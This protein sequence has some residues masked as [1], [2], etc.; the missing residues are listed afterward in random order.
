[1]SSLPKKVTVLV[2]SREQKPLVFPKSIAWVG[3][4]RETQ[5]SLSLRVVRLDYGDYALEGYEDC[6]VVERKGSLSEL[7]SN[8]F[9]T[10]LGRQAKS[11]R[12][13]VDYCMY[14]YLLLEGNPAALYRT[15]KDYR[16]VP[17]ELREPG[18]V[19]D[20]LL[21]TLGAYGIQLLWLGGARSQA[22][23][24]VTGDVVLRLLLRHAAEKEAWS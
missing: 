17:E 19:V 15:A 11:F 3:D 13:L 1:M 2:D 24:R 12:K 8:L 18:Y 9:T 7:F 4:G 20:V 16:G 23:K 22:A 14:P 5:I 6:G 21:R 10:D